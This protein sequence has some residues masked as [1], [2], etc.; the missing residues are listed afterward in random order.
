[1]TLEEFNQNPMIRN[2]L[3]EG[4]LS[5]KL[6]TYI[7]MYQYYHSKLKSLNNT[8]GKKMIAITWTGEGFRVSDA[9]VYVAIS[10][11][12]SLEDQIKDK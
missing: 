7:E 3:K 2:L 4:F 9:T 11:V 5:P 12:K 8:K 6:T 10:K 1:M